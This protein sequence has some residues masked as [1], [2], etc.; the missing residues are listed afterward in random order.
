MNEPVRLR[1]FLVDQARRWGMDHP[2]ESA[3]LFRSWEEIV[4]E[5]VALRCAPVSLGRGVLGV[6]TGSAAWATELRYLAPAVIQKVNRELGVSLVKELKVALSRESEGPRCQSELAGRSAPEA[7]GGDPRARPGVIRGRALSE[8]E[9]LCS[10][11]ADERLA[12]AAR[13]AIAAAARLGREP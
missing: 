5:R 10:G 6:C 9:A 4:G 2:L 7:P 13:R 11:I 3:R 12:G 8:A 1:S